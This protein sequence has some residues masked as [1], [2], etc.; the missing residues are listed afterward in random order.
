MP[1][2]RAI[3]PA[4]VIGIVAIAGGAGS[5][6]AASLAKAQ[7]E[8]AAKADA[9]ASAAAQ[10][11]PDETWTPEKEITVN[12]AEAGGARLLRTRLALVG[13][14][15]AIAR[16]KQLEPRLRDDLIRAVS[17]KVFTDLEGSAGKDRLRGEILARVNAILEPYG[18]G[19]KIGQVFFHS[20]V[21]Q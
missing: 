20:F 5:G 21:V 17:D 11:L 9:D 6:L 18:E 13:P 4:A 1:T 2:L 15:P 7:V 3:L 14:P 12:L 8:S 10:A 19:E 16:C